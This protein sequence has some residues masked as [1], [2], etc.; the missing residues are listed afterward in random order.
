MPHHVLAVAESDSYLKW[1]VSLLAQLPAPV[2]VDVVVARSP[3]RP[4]AA[5]QAAALGG[6][7]YSGHPI[8]VVSPAQLKRTVEQERPDAVLLACT[9]PTAHAY[10]E[11]LSTAAHR[12][13]LVAGIPGI[14]LPARRKAWAFRGA[15][16]LMVVHSHREVE[17]YD[18]V[19]LLT[20]RSARI[21]LA[22]IPFLAPDAQLVAE[23]SGGV[24]IIEPAADPAL[25]NRV[26]FA[27]QGK[28]PV[29]RA[30][31]ERILLA[32][33][34]LAATHPGLRVVVKTRGVPGEFH[35]HYEHFHYEVLW[36][37]LIASGQVSDP[38]LLEFAA[39]SMAEQLR[40]AAA[41]VTV[42]STAVLEAM[43]LD[44]PVLL[45]DDFGV[46]EEM[47]NQVFVGSGCQ[48]SLASLV[49]GDFHHPES[50]W[51]TENYFHP[52][53]D[54]TWIDLLD[55]LIKAAAAGELPPL[56]EGLDPDRSPQRRRL[57][58]FRLSWVGSELSRVRQRIRTR[59]TPKDP[60]EAGA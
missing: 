16:D 12:P 48:R 60:L 18:R 57:D 35:T 9:G 44:I 40:T 26:L 59:L 39:G 54:N 6:T 4:S 2:R 43:A 49:Q 38:A 20:G 50:W 31:R 15:I 17:E 33:A 5:Q 22:T 3:I 25:R 21:G 7:G 8:A 24:P 42:S 1:A 19:R 23:A 56:A 36:R 29:R 46:S 52:V 30:E 51:S 27:T 53:S 14:A 47:I 41:L 13:V 58:R 45:I 28:V 34:E 32:L 10:Q 37:D 55:E 11:V